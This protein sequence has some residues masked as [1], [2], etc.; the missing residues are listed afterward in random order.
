MN[1]D[2][3]AA[4]DILSSLLLAIIITIITI[5]VVGTVA[6]PLFA[7]LPSIYYCFKLLFVFGFVI[8]HSTKI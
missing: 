8:C 2:H 4:Y 6:V 5:L 3:T 1:R 7:N